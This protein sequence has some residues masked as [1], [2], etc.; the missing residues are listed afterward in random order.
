MIGHHHNLEMKA[1]KLV[2]AYNTNFE[3]ILENG[4]LQFVALA[5]NYKENQWKY[6][7]IAIF[8]ILG[9]ILL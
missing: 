1:F 2:Y 6:Y 8:L 4:L 7:F 9:F 3:A 5:Y